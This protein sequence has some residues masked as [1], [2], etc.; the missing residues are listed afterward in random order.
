MPIINESMVIA[1]Y[2]GGKW[3]IKNASKYVGKKQ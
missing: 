2:E 1:K 3:W